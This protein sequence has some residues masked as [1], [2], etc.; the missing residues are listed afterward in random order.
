MKDLFQKNPFAGLVLAAVAGIATGDFLLSGP[1]PGAQS[2]FAPQLVQIIAGIV[3]AVCLCAAWAPEVVGRILFWPGVFAAFLAIHTFH[4]RAGP[5]WQLLKEAGSEPSAWRVVGTVLESRRSPASARNSVL[6]RVEL[7]EREPEA[8]LDP[9]LSGAT[10][11]TPPKGGSTRNRVKLAIP[12]RLHVRMPGPTPSYGTRLQL[13]GTLRTIPP[14]RNP[15]AF[16]FRLWQARRGVFQELDVRAE[17]DVEVLEG[18]AGNPIFEAAQ[19]A[20]QRMLEILAA[21]MDRYPIVRGL[22]LAMTLGETEELPPAE[23]ENFRITG[24]L[25]LFSVSGLHV[26]MIAF[27][28]WLLF[29]PVPVQARVVLIIA[30]LFFYSAVTGMKPSSLRAAFMGSLVLGGL[31][32]ERPVAPVNS[33]MAAAFFLLLGDTNQLFN[34]G[35][36]L[37]FFVVLSIFWIGLPVQQ[38][39]RK[40][41]GPDAFLPRGL[42]SPWDVARLWAANELGGLASI[43]LSAWIGSLPLIV[44][45][46]HLIS[47]SA[48]PVNLFAVPMA[49]AILAVAMLSMLSGILWI[50][51]AE[52]FNHTNILLG[53]LLLR[54]IQMA[55]AVPFAAIAVPELRMNPP[56][57]EI[58]IFD[59]GAGGASGL[60]I[61]QTFYWI[62]SGNA[63][64]AETVGI[65]WMTSQGA[66]RIEGIFV[67]HGDV[68]HT[69]GAKVLAQTF[70]VR[71]VGMGV[72][73]DR[74]QTLKSLRHFLES[75]GIPKR[76]LFMGDRI[77][78]RGRWMLRILYPPTG[79][80]LRTADDKFLVCVLE[81]PMAHGDFR[82]LWLGDAGEDALRN[83]MAAGELR[84]VTGVVLGKHS[85]E[86]R[87]SE[88]ILETLDAQWFVITSASFPSDEALPQGWGARLAAAGSRVY[89]Q[90]ETGAVIVRIWDDA[91][92]EVEPFLKEGL[93][94]AWINGEDE[95]EP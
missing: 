80:P 28:L 51:F 82:V 64:F 91:H 16:D 45:Y 77:P 4:L 84:Q 18:R 87:I 24:T 70:P 73:A 85:E 37:S 50:G 92:V 79:K 78:L 86:G 36:Q 17:R 25:H 95:A 26:G 90:D 46:Y 72:L 21:G 39:M 12:A 56:T 83:I 52:I 31:L 48:I 93:R 7:A 8:S 76:L 75:E 60:R 10:G 29:K 58:V 44:A 43:S 57:A 69:G 53:G 65:P 13:W 6:L 22:V 55:A 59:A 32:L 41:L 9:L 23:M 71:F 68:K 88:E 20:K 61:G 49:F 66:T 14:L 19:R 81:K 74:S 42:Y 35:F 67:T 94:V 34:P 2:L 3:A 38:W 47:L 63:H 33:L 62:D 40:H 15:G 11:Q 89:R 5:G 27:L 54:G 30:C 1:L